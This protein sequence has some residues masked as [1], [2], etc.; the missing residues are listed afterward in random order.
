WVVGG[1]GGMVAVPGGKC[2]GGGRVSGKQNAAPRVPGGPARAQQISALFGVQPKLT[3]AP[4]VNRLSV[5]ATRW[6]P[7]AAVNAAIS[8]AGPPPR[9]TRAYSP[10]GG[11]RHVGGWRRFVVRWCYYTAVTTSLQH[12]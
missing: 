7:A 11:F 12:V 5:M 2:V 3:R 6:P 10:P 4:P 8:P 1:V 9:T